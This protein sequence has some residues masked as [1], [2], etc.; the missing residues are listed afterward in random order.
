MSIIRHSPIPPG[1]QWDPSHEQYPPYRD[2]QGVW[3]KAFF[4]H[5]DRNMGNKKSA[6]LADEALSLFQERFFPPIEPNVPEAE[7]TQD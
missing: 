2:Q 5:L 1:V 3:E 7:S 6:E 4:A